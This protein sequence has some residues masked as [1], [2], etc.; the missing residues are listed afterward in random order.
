MALSFI[1]GDFYGMLR[2]IGKR[3]Q[4]LN[5]EKEKKP[6]NKNKNKGSDRI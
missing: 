1:M 6:K 4:G 3:I 5:S 2:K